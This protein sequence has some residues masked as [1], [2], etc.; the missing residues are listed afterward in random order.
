MKK[1]GQCLPKFQC[2]ELILHPQQ[3]T[4]QSTNYRDLMSTTVP[5][6][7]KGPVRLYCLH[8]NTI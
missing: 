3:I 5:L 4:L 1:T 6:R 2:P 8:H 7:N